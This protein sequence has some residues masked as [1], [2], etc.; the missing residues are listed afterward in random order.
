MEMITA[1]RPW[2]NHTGDIPLHLEYPEGSMY[3][4]LKEIADTYP[5]Y[6]AFDFM[7]RSTTYKVLL[8]NIFHNLIYR[9]I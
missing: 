6:V 2:E 5:N 3:D 9:T 1:K 7:G 8:Q 4:A